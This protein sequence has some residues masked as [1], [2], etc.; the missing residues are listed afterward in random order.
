MQCRAPGPVPVL[1][2]DERVTVELIADGFHLHPAILR[3]AAQLAEGR[4][5]LITDAIAATGL[6]D[7]ECLLGTQRVRITAGQARLIGGD[8]LAGSTLT[9]DRA[10]RNAVRSGIPLRAAVDAVTVTP[11]R[12]PGSRIA[13]A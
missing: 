5:A 13:Q 12:A 11:A 8:S 1:L 9:L 7:G 2:Q 10:L 4:F 6:G 3:Q